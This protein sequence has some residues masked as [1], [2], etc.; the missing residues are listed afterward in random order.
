MVAPA[1]HG[2]LQVQRQVME[3]LRAAQNHNFHIHSKKTEKKQRA[4]AAR[5]IAGGCDN[6]VTRDYPALN[7]VRGELEAHCYKR[8]ALLVGPSFWRHLPDD[9]HTFEFRAFLFAVLSRCGA[10]VHYLLTQKRLRLD[11]QILLIFDPPD[12]VRHKLI[13]SPEH[14]R[15]EWF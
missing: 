8:L 6:W 7:T 9:C 13:T 3:C 11:E 4:V 2:I 1:P 10:T 15:S 5:A 14:L 12:V